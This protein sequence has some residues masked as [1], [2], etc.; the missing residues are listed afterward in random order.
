M[1]FWVMMLRVEKGRVWWD[2]VA[3][4]EGGVASVVHCESKLVAICGKSGLSAGLTAG[5]LPRR[6]VIRIV[7]G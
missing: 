3:A 2:G 5:Y 1:L 7:E 6:L 4:L